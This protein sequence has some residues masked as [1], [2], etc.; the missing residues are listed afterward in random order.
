MSLKEMISCMLHER[1]LPSKIWAE[2]LNYASYILNK[3][4]RRSIEDRTPFEA[5]IGDKPDVTHFCIFRSR[6][7]AHIPSEK[8][9]DLDPHST[10]CIFVGYL[11]YVKGYYR[12]IHPS[13]N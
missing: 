12:L 1:S 4:P 5:R 9:K 6:E 3:S 11:D 2:A 13:T 8:R 10:P 7:W